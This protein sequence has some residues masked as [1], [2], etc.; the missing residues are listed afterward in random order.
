MYDL[1][2]QVV[3]TNE[4]NRKQNRK[5]KKCERHKYNEQQTKI[6]QKQISVQFALNNNFHIVKSKRNE[7]IRD[8]FEVDPIITRDDPNLAFEQNLRRETFKHTI[9]LEI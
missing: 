2:F 3:V 7:F 1:I 9:C 6:A 8:S 5:N 4:I